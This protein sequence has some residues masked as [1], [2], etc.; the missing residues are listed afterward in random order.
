MEELFTKD[1]AAHLK[2]LGDSLAAQYRAADPFPHAVLESFLPPEP[3]EA[4]LREFPSPKQVDWKQ[5]DNE[6]EKKLAFENVEAM[7]PNIRGVLYFLN[8]AIVLDFL[9]RLTGISAL[10]PDPHFFGGGLHQIVPGGHLEVHADFNKYDRLNLDRRLNLL[11]YLNKDW[12]EEWGG[13]LELWDTSMTRCVKR[14]LPVFNRCVIF[15]TT[16]TAFHGH[17]RPLACP[18][19]RTRKSLATYY[20]SNG[21]PAEEQNQKHST[22]FQTRPE[23]VTGINGTV[24]VAKRVIRSLLPPVVTDAFKKVKQLRGD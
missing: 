7:P 11:L 9:E 5:F 15:S 1:L 3:L 14:V 13:H 4:V 22:L 6:E 19:D 17:P 10:I 21:R 8:S 18:P 16:S 12:S 2:R 23:E 24:R 20:Y